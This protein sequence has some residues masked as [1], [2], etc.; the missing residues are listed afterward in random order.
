MEFQRMVVV[1]WTALWL[2]G[3]PGEPSSSQ[4]PRAHIPLPHAGDTSEPDLGRIE[5]FF[6]AGVDANVTPV[7]GAPTTN[8]TVLVRRDGELLADADVFFNDS[9]GNLVAHVLTGIDGRATMNDSGVS[10]ASVVWLQEIQYGEQTVSKY[11]IVSWLDLPRDRDLLIQ[12]DT[13]FVS[14]LPDPIV[15]EITMPAAFAGAL[16]YTV[17]SCDSSRTTSDAGQVLLTNYPRCTDTQPAP[18]VALALDSEGQILASSTALLPV[19]NADVNRVGL[20]MPVW[21]TEVLTVDLHFSVLPELAIYQTNMRAPFSQASLVSLESDRPLSADLTLVVPDLREIGARLGIHIL[22]A[23]SGQAFRMSDI[24]D[25]DAQSRTYDLEKDVVAAP[26]GLALDVS[27]PKRPSVFVESMSGTEL[28]DVWSIEM[29]RE[30]SAEM[31]MTGDVWYEWNAF[32]PAG[33]SRNFRFPE[34]VGP[35][36]LAVADGPPTRRSADAIDSDALAGYAD[37]L[38]LDDGSIGDGFPFHTHKS[39]ARTQVNAPQ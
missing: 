38:D 3:C 29:V 6:D 36:A 32:G 4:V 5:P 27:A 11:R 39:A 23:S 12:R 17:S 30:T 34:L 1:L 35:V 37:F 25:V 26:G 18:F 2:T 28:G 10:Q 33:P 15:V 22:G 19:Q 31:P 8:V 21:R 13:G 9:A 20:V 16:S 7:S 14:Q 24:L